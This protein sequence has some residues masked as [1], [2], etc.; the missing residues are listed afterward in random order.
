MSNY[1]QK[2]LEELVKFIKN[3]GGQASFEELLKWAEEND[4]GTITLSI[5]L[6]DLIEEGII[7]A[8]EGFLEP[9]GILTAYPIPK[10]VE[11]A[12]EIETIKEE[13]K[14]EV[15]AEELKE[16]EEIKREEA[17]KVEEEAEIIPIE[18]AE[19]KFEAIEVAEETSPETAEAELKPEVKH[20]A[21]KP[22]DLEEDLN[23]AIEYL[24]EYWSVGVIRFL[25][26]LKLLGVSK[27]DAI[28]KK[29]IDLGYVT[30]S[31]IGVVNA[32]NKLPKIYRPKKLTEF[33]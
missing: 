19:G 14:G 23:K 13:V 7:S 33:I 17:V 12:R 1:Y 16:V 3:K 5:A 4:I 29:L 15:E 9:E 6:N 11:I 8:P 21:E 28:L 25:E 24:N 26:D 32:T 31:P 2:I 27:P 22:I 18:E 10:T 30:Y 20:E